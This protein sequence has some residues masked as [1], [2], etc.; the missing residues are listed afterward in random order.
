MNTPVWNY[1]S[2]CIILSHD[3]VHNSEYHPIIKADCIKFMQ[4]KISYNPRYSRIIRKPLISIT[5][6]ITTNQ[7]GIP[8]N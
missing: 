1:A 6:T 4:I 3:L 7:V 8:S 5:R 2:V